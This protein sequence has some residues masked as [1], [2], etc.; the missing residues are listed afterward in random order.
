MKFGASLWPQ[1]TS[2][3]ALRDAAIV[4]DTVGF[5]TLWTWDHFY[6]LAGAEEKPNFEST[7]ILGALSPLTKKAKLGAL[8]QGVTYRHPAVIAN[9]A[10]THDNV[11]NG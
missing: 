11:S 6:A 5:E 8:V 2:W 4:V 7:T 9:M 10:A 1:N 3:E